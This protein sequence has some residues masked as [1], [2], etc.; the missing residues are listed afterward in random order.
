MVAPEALATPRVPGLFAPPPSDF[1]LSSELTRAPQGRGPARCRERLAVGAAAA[2]RAERVDELA[3]PE[4]GAVVAP[5]SPARSE[6]RDRRVPE[7]EA[8]DRGLAG[9]E[10]GV[11]RVVGVADQLELEPTVMLGDG[12]VLTG[13]EPGPRNSSPVAAFHLRRDGWGVGIPT[14]DGVDMRQRACGEY[15]AKA[16][17]PRATLL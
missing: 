12:G 16:G 2:N 8:A 7:V 17:M 6:A 10:A 4:L 15:E 9:D 1:R 13:T 11:D 5:L 3:D 14:C